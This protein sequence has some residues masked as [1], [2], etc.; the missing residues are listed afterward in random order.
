MES[1]GDKFVM[2]VNIIVGDK[3]S[4]I[5][6]ED[7]ISPGICIGSST[8]VTYTVKSCINDRHTVA[9]NYTTMYGPRALL[10]CYFIY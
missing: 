1:N 5:V 7:W 2:N 4:I 6:C 3:K 9:E 10:E 8:L